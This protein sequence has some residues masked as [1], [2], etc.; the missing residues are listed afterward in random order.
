VLF[1]DEEAASGVQWE[2]ARFWDAEED[3]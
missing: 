3:E 1:A 2:R